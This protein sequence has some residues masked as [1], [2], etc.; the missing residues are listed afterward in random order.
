MNLI[1][2]IA[3]A[4]LA[5][6]VAYGVWSGRDTGPI[7]PE[8][9]SEAQKA[10]ILRLHEIK[11]AGGRA[12]VE[13]REE[14]MGQRLYLVYQPERIADG[15]GWLRSYFSSARSLMIDLEEKAPGNA[16]KQV[17][18]DV[19]IPTVDS[20]GKSGHSRGMLVHYDWERL[21]GANFDS[22]IAAIP[23]EQIEKVSFRRL[24]ELSAS[25]YCADQKYLEQTPRFCVL[26]AQ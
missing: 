19:R 1:A 9:A 18:I 2:K 11:R 10:Q 21:R 4:S 12:F 23:A 6:I 7:Y 25:E 13:A 16:Y 14:W 24:G 3:L 15:P 26:A 8:G 20:L 5:G 22:Y 17:V